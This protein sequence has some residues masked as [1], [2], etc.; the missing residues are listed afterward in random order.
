VVAN[1]AFKPTATLLEA[2]V[3]APPALPPIAILQ[4]P[5]AVLQFHNLLYYK[6]MLDNQLQY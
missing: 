1:K 4:Q 3:L 2:V 6:K 5:V